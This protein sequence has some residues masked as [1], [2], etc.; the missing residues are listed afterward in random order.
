MSPSKD[1]TRETPEP[2]V[3]SLGETPESL[4]SD[5]VYIAENRENLLYIRVYLLYITLVSD[6]HAYC[7]CGK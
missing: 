6:R 5:P 3:E 4:T 1:M 7:V 2:L